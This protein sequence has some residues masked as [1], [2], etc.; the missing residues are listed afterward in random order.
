MATE[1]IKY[2][3]FSVSQL[4]FQKS[5]KTK[6][7]KQYINKYVFFNGKKYQYTEILDDPSKSKYSDVKTVAYGNINNMKYN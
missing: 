5:I 3:M 7:G 6:L 2:F 1:N 4:D